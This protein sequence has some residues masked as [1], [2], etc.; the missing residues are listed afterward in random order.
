LGGEEKAYEAEKKSS[1]GWRKKIFCV[2]LV[3]KKKLI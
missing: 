3:E 2:M 1:V